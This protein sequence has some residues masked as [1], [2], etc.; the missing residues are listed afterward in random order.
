MYYPVVADP[1]KAYETAFVRF[2]AREKKATKRL[3]AIPGYRDYVVVAESWTPT[4]EYTLF[5]YPTTPPAPVH[6]ERLLKA[7][8]VVQKARLVHGR[9][10]VG[11]QGGKVAHFREA[12]DMAGA[13]VHAREYF[14][15]T[16]GAPD[17]YVL[18][19][20]AQGL[21]GFVPA[22]YAKFLEM[23]REA[24]ILELVKGWR[25]WDLY[26]L[27]G[28]VEHPMKAKC[29]AVWVSDRPSVEDCLRALKEPNGA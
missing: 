2:A 18:G 9:M 28:V 29:R 19:L 27:S 25:T 22:C 5:R 13:V 7:L 3:R 11:V 6:V 10:D 8:Q 1:T 16:T 21:T 4:G 23:P 26:D 24:A 20:V 15:P 14:F 17:K 12:L